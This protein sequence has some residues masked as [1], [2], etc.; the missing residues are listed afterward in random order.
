MRDYELMKLSEDVI[1]LLRL[2]E[3]VQVLI[4]LAWIAQL[5]ANLTIIVQL[6]KIKRY[7]KRI[8]QKM[9]DFKPESQI[10][11]E[12]EDIENEQEENYIKERNENI[13]ENLENIEKSY[14]SIEFNK[15]TLEYIVLTILI[16]IIAIIIFIEFK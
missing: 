3:G 10:N 16:I 1:K 15:Q 4:F 11:A 12:I 13:L 2:I 9:Y 14:H 6:P 5:I 7:Q 8:Y